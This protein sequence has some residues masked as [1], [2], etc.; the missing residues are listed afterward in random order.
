METGVAIESKNFL[1]PFDLDNGET[2]IAAIP[3]PTR[4]EFQSVASF[5][6]SLFLKI[7]NGEISL[8]IF[9][10]DYKV[11]IRE[12]LGEKKNA[13]EMLEAINAMVERRISWD[14]I[15]NEQGEK[16]FSNANEMSDD[17]RDAASAGMLFFYSLYRY[18][19]A[20]FGNKNVK[21]LITSS[22]HTELPAYIK[23]LFADYKKNHRI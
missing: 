2:A 3:I 14:K 12:Y 7:Q 9:Q 13:K 18:A 4:E 20:Q 15:F 16:I 21:D 5:L 23:K 19:K 1:I 17:E 22:P 8:T 11:I 6:G 10:K